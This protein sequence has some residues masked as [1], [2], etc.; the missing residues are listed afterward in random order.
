MQKKIIKSKPKLK[1]YLRKQNGITL[2]AL[3]LTIIILLILAGISIAMLTGDNGIIRQANNAQTATIQGQ[4]KEQIALAWNTVITDKLAEG[5]S[6]EVT[7]S[8]LKT[9]LTADGADIKEVTESG[10]S[11]VV[12]FNN[13]NKY[14]IDENGNIVFEGTGSGE[15]GGEENVES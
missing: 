8:D 2:I 10:T 3:V 4:E 1:N 12:E 9:Q 15:E 14:T 13:G 6:A 5:Q 11:I 7:A